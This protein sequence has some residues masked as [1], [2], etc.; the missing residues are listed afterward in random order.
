MTNPPIR[1]TEVERFIHAEV[2]EVTRLATNAANPHPVTGT[3][4]DS[5][6]AIWLAT[7]NAVLAATARCRGD[8]VGNVAKV[9]RGELS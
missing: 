7:Q 9:L 1:P 6:W 5:A 2:A 4:G 8:A 3:V